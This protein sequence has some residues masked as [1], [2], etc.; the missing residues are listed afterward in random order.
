MPKCVQQKISCSARALRGLALGASSLTIAA[1][2]SA[3]PALAQQVAAN[4]QGPIETVTVTA[5]YVTQNVQ[6]APLAIS[7]V[8]SEDLEQRGIE[9]LGQL[10]T[11]VPSLT[12]TQ[13]PAAFGNAV[14][15]YIRGVGQYDT[16]YASE[17]GV[18]M[19]IDDVYF[20][21]MS[22]SEMQLLDLSRVEILKGPQGVLG[23]KNDIGGA[24]KLFTQKPTDDNSGYL[25]ATYGAFDDIE[26]KGATNLTVIPGH[27]YLRL[28]G[29]SKNQN[30]FVNIIDFACANPG[31][32]GSLPRLTT[33][34]GCKLGTEGGTDVAAGR[35]A[36]RAVVNAH[37]EDNFAIDVVR[38]NSELTPDVLFAA[39]AD[40]TNVYYN[41]GNG[42]QVA[43][44]TAFLGTSA[45]TATSIPGWNALINVPTYGIPWDQRFI[46]NNPFKTTYATYISSEGAQYT[47][48]EM[49]HS[50]SMTN[51]FDYD[52]FD[53]VHFK[54]IT[55][56]R[57][58]QGAYSN[59]SD[60]SPL[61][62]QL[63][64]TYPTDREFQQE[65][66]FTGKLFDNHL[67]WTAGAFYYNRTNTAKGAVLLD[68]DYNEGV[69]LGVP[70]LESLAFEQNDRYDA[71]NTSFYI[72]GIYHIWDDLE[73]FGGFR[74]TSESKTYYFDHL[75][76]PPGYPD[77]GFFR[78]AVNPA[79]DFVI[80]ASCPANAPLVGN[81][82]TAERPDYRAG[83]DYHLTDDL[84][85]Y[86][87]FSTGYRSG[88]FNSRP[89][90]PLQLNSYGPEEIR[91]YEI[92]A[93]TQWF[94]DR[95]RVNVALFDAD[96]D[97]TITP[98]ARTDALGLP[99]VDYVNLGS[100][101]DKGYEIELT[102]API[103]NLLITAN[104]SYVDVTANPVPGAQPGF[105]DG[106]TAAAFAAGI[107][108]Q[109]APGTVYK[110]SAPILFPQRTANFAI[111][112]AWDMP[113]GWGM[114]TPRLDYDWQSTIYQDANNNPYTEI[115]A[116]GLLNGR[117]AW[118]APQGGWELS[119]LVTN[120]ADK[121][122]FL[123]MTD[124]AVF[125]EGTVEAQ[126]GPPREWFL[127]LK[128]TF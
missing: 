100:S 22:G 95:L 51:V 7:V 111:Q 33:N 97:H 126:P 25:S 77:G 43:P 89:F 87:Q 85:G 62:F 48:G 21:T 78:D 23:G 88:G 128:K 99:W 105:L 110:N 127:T 53:W 58:Y 91:S 92:G 35:L 3:S 59:D 113:N 118:Q 93:K 6:A 80:N 109:V 9:D 44:R 107:C 26:V 71:E 121:K 28:S 70:F 20:G 114:L 123:N 69:V 125:G 65:E 39:D 42:L 79:C 94:D 84:M 81:K 104:T 12:L 68:A 119:L 103:D 61:S 11:S 124:F 17:P 1:A 102:A 18:G 96:Y 63:T 45:S 120:I 57:Q 116:R 31:L 60:V 16:A 52:V 72:H 32:A 83:V 38:D 19:Y 46:P 74:Y 117:L 13:A 10:G 55:G 122:Y 75:D 86:F 30:G 15:T 47:N 27:L 64:T 108:P 98:L 41:K 101:T 54:M 67:E 112:Y 24:I 76:K 106:C 34:E 73:V 8:S 29:M 5:Q 82:T 36:I 56:Y 4:P 40:G 50:W 37:M 14:Q 90:D 66:R 49:M 115:P 2:L